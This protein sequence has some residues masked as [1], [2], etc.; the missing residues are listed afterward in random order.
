MADTSKKGKIDDEQ[1]NINDEQTQQDELDTKLC[2]VLSP[3]PRRNTAVEELFSLPPSTTA[4]A[5]LRS[6]IPLS[7]SDSQ[8]IG[9]PKYIGAT[10]DVTDDTV[11]LDDTLTSLDRIADNAFFLTEMDRDHF[12]GRPPI[13]LYLT[14]DDNIMSKYQCFARKH[15]ELFEAG[16]EDIVSNA[17]GRNKPIVLGQVGIRCRHCNALPPKQ[18]KRG[19]AY[20]PAKLEGVYQAAHNMALL[21][22]GSFCQNFDSCLRNHIETLRENKSTAGGGKKDWAE[23][24]AVLGVFEDADGLRFEKS[25]NYRKSNYLEI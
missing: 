22:F 15:I 1:T 24:A 7:T 3:L 18:R 6:D 20:Y 14:C 21:H 17:Q 12:T 2:A 23:R 9:V 25:L 11:S 4:I 8:S 13:Q 5:T 10:M 16:E 19:A